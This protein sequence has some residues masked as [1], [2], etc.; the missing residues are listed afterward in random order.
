M[1]LKGMKMEVKLLRKLNYFKLEL[2]EQFNKVVSLNIVQHVIMLR[3]TTLLCRTKC[4]LL[5]LTFIC[6]A[7]FL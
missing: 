7:N 1:H 5:N 3:L 2:N 6:S 4:R